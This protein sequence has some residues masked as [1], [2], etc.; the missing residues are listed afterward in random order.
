MI[1]FLKDP[2][3]RDIVLVAEWL[4]GKHKALSSKLQNSKKKKPQI[5]H[6]KSLG[7]DK[8]FKISIQKSIAFLYTDN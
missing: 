8:H 6:Q 4:P 1:L 7:A 5:F 3:T 2:R